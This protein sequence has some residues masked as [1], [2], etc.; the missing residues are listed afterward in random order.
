M[1]SIVESNGDS[2]VNDFKIILNDNGE[3]AYSMTSEVQRLR[4]LADVFGKSNH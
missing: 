3:Y 4:F 2:I 1:I